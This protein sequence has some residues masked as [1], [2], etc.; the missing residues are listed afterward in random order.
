[1]HDLFREAHRP[2]EIRTGIKKA[3]ADLSRERSLKRRREGKERRG[4]R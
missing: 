3:G 1:M 4:M 2:G